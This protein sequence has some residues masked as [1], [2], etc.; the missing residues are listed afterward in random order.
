MNTIIKTLII[1]FISIIS[2]YAQNNISGY[3]LDESNK[4]LE[5]ANVILHS[6]TSKEIVTGVI[7][8][9]SGF[10]KIENVENG[11]YY[12][13]ISVLG[14]KLKRSDAF[15]IENNSKT[16]DFN[17]AEDVLD[18]IVITHKRPVISKRPRN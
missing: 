14:F 18:E 1:F 7:S 15:L 8:S 2:G 11:N 17:L 5:F 6:A 3:I 10:Y 13:E 9:E 4:P 16:F 12:L